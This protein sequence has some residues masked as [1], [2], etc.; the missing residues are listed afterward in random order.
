MSRAVGITDWA[1][2]AKSG[3]GRR[4]AGDGDGDGVW[5]GGPLPPYLAVT[6]VAVVTAAT[7]AAAAA[8]AN[9]SWVPVTA[10]GDALGTMM[11]R[12]RDVVFEPAAVDSGTM[13]A[14]LTALA[15]A[16][17]GGAST[18]VPDASDLP[19]AHTAVAFSIGAHATANASVRVDMTAR[20]G[21][22]HSPP[23]SSQE[24]ARVF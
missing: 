6:A 2:V 15:V 22:W 18:A 9:L 4:A 5:G 11:T 8:A 13:A 1:A 7:A 23:C 14:L 24:N 17:A 21:C 10:V 19:A 16:V 12:E 3:G 20:G